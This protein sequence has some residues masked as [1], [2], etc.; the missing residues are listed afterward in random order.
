LGDVTT[1]L[2]LT[3]LAQDRQTGDALSRYVTGGAGGGAA[4]AATGA[5]VASAPSRS[6]PTFAQGDAIGQYGAAIQGNESGGRY[7]IVGP[8]HP[9]LG[10]ALGAYQVMEANV[11][12]WTKEALGQAMT[13]QEFL[14]NP[15]AQDAV[16]RHKFGQYVA[17]T[18]SP[19]DAA[20]MWFTGRPLA[21]AR[22]SRTRSARPGSAT[23]ICSR[24][25][26]PGRAAHPRSP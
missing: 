20:S 5:P 3:K 22:I 21:R 24:P 14:A 26:L 1:G 18:G 23:S 15:Q 11:G 4:P 19:E 2:A 7:D 25:A 8:T 6:L 13:P 12:P 16:F 10:R 9:R 17:Q